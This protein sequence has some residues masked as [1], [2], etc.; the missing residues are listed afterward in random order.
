MEEYEGTLIIGI[1]MRVWTLGTPALKYLEGQGDL[2]KRVQ[3][4]DDRAYSM[5]YRG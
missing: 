2:A 4:G 1:S 3:N 5:A